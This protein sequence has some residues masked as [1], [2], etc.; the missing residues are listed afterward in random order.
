MTGKWKEVKLS[1]LFEISMGSK[2]DF[3]K[4]TFENPEVSYVGRSAMFNGNKKTKVDLID[5]VEPYNAGCITVAL[6]GSIG[7]TFLQDEK[8]YTSQNVSVLI[9]NEKHRMNKYHK[10]FIITLLKHQFSLKFVAF[11]RELNRYIRESILLPMPHTDEGN[12]DWDYMESQIKLTINDQRNFI[13]KLLYNDI[14]AVDSLDKQNWQSY[15][16]DDLFDVQT[17]KYYQAKTEYNPGEIPFITQT[18][19]NNG[20]ETY[21][22]EEFFQLEKGNCVIIGSIGITAFYQESDFLSDLK[23]Y[24]IYGDA[25][26]GSYM[27]KEIGLFLATILNMEQFKYGYGRQFYSSNLKETR[28]KLP[29]VFNKMN[30]MYVPDWQYMIDY[31]KVKNNYVINEFLNS[32]NNK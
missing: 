6:G 27:N 5:G 15:I 26:K 22:D 9:P 3:S 25:K 10:L 20:V 23:I 2:L 7:S 17:V 16:I 31:I 29:S 24:K 13:N 19:L 32:S 1:E 18:A 30:N 8:F 11:G 28:I 12:I 4:M 21:V 14:P